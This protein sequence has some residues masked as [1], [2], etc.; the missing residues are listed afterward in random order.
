MWEEPETSALQGLA[1]FLSLSCFIQA[2]ALPCQS[3]LPR[4]L[5]HTCL[6][7]FFTQGCIRVKNSSML[8]I[9]CAFWM[10]TCMLM[11]PYRPASESEW[12]CTR[13]FRKEKRITQ[14]KMPKPLLRFF[15][16][17]SFFTLCLK[18]SYSVTLASFPVDASSSYNWP[19]PAQDDFCLLSPPGIRFK[20]L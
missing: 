5:F 8:F 11:P 10:M 9:L 6:L 2:T 15:D 14:I 19:L 13:I 4:P 17:A 3:L 16:V 1:F 18:S 20:S 7:Y 12:A